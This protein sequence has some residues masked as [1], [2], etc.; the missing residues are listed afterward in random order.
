MLLD[1]PPPHSQ[2]GAQRSKVDYSVTDRG[3]NPEIKITVIHE[4][5][6]RLSIRG[7]EGDRRHDV[8]RVNMQEYA[9]ET[10]PKLRKSH[11]AGDEIVGCLIEPIGLTTRAF[12][13]SLQTRRHR[14]VA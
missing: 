13:C 5:D 4:Q 2:E 8:V 10:P 7:G 1:A 3:T 12:D 11:P 6:T 9:I 14:R